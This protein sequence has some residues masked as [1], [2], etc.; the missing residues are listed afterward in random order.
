MNIQT[1]LEDTNTKS[2]YHHR[3]DVIA[4]PPVHTLELVSQDLTDDGVPSVFRKI[5]WLRKL[6]AIKE[7][8]FYSAKEIFGD[9][10]YTNR[11]AEY[12]GKEFKRLVQSGQLGNIRLVR[13]RTNQSLEYEIY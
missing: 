12:Y 10:W 3:E 4:D 5:D 2:P 8:G 11:R 6:I 13:K 9:W 1:Y 7:P